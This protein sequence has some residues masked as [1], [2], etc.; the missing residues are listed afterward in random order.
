VGVYLVYQSMAMNILLLLIVSIVTVTQG[1]I[2]IQQYHTKYR[3]LSAV[4]MGT[5]QISS[6]V[7]N[8]D[9]SQRLIVGSSS[10]A[11]TA[12]AVRTTMASERMPPTNIPKGSSPDE[13]G[14][15]T[16]SSTSSSS[17]RIAG[18]MYR[19]D[20]PST[21][22]NNNNN[23]RNRSGK[24]KR[25]LHQCDISIRKRQKVKRTTA[26]HCAKSM[27]QEEDRL[28]IDTETSAESKKEDI[29]DNNEDPMQKEVDDNATEEFRFDDYYIEPINTGIYIY[30]YIYIYIHMYVYIYIHIYIYTYIYIYM[31]IYIY[32]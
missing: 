4:K 10:N 31:Y 17:S 28:S 22:D 32:I 1:K 29:D 8:N 13:N 15:G 19:K 5:G 2:F 6:T 7:I 26:L 24:I 21:G 14:G 30:I 20:I 12:A 25:T 18:N 3:P 23:N 16:S 9:M 27:I 11:A